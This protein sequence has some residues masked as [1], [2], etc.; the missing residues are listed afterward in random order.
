[1]ISK[2]KK[3]YNEGY[4]DALEQVEAVLQKRDWA[5]ASPAQP[6]V[7]EYYLSEKFGRIRGSII[8]MRNRTA[9]PKLTVKQRIQNALYDSDEPLAQEDLARILGICVDN[10]H[11]SPNRETRKNQQNAAGIAAERKTSQFGGFGGLL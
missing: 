6:N 9:E 10:M 5:A 2:W 4:R 8:Q 1:M 3:G 11:K 7:L